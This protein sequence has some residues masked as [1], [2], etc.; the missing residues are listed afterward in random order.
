LRQFYH[1]MLLTRQRLNVPP[2]PITWFQNLI[3]TMG[4]DLEISVARKNGQPVAGILTL[5]YK[6]ILVYKYG[7]SD[8]AQHRLGGVHA[9]LWRAIRQAK[10]LGMREI[11]FG[12]SDY[13]DLGLATFKERWG[14]AR[15]SLQYWRSPASSASNRRMAWIERVGKPVLARVPTF[16]LPTIGKLVTKHLG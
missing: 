1:L 5:R 11:D 6:D 10:E 8:A 13:D 2:H 7:G 9:L 12:R 4:E 14:C 15:S 3:A 16:F